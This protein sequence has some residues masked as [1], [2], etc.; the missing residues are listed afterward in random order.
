[1]WC[2]CNRGW[3][4]LNPYLLMQGKRVG[5]YGPRLGR[6]GVHCQ[7]VY[8]CCK[9]MRVNAAPKPDSAQCEQEKQECAGPWLKLESLIPHHWMSAASH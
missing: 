4:W 9:L 8:G 2:I 1:M 5:G 3:A 6:L 7:L